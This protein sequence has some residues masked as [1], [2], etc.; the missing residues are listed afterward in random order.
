MKLC[1]ASDSH[2]A[3]GMLCRM[4]EAEQPDTLLFLGDGGEEA[5]RAA[6]LF[7]VPA[8]CVAGNCDLCSPEPPTRTVTQGGVTMFMAHG[9]RFGVKQGLGVFAGAV[10]QAG[11]QVGLF[12]HTHQ[13]YG[14]EWGGVWL[15]NP[16]SIREGYYLCARAAGGTF[17]VRKGR[18]E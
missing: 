5:Q 10:R 7:G 17:E 1:I 8:L 11:T 12:G 6:K 13:P 4:L 18:V 9:H 14:R 15:Y 16:G 3:F 2:G